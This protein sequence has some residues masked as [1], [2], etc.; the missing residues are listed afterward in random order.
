MEE[1]RKGKFLVDLLNHSIHQ[2]NHRM[3][4]DVRIS[5]IYIALE[6]L[7]II[8]LYNVEINT[9]RGQFVKLYH[10]QILQKSDKIGL[11]CS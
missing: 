3:G 6:V 1:M 7:I 11:D 5:N 4:T 9:K 2:T 10:T 8:D